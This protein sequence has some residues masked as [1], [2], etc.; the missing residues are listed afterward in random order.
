MGVRPPWALSPV[1]CRAE[2]CRKTLS[3]N[4][5]V[6]FCK[7]HRRLSPEVQRHEADYAR[8]RYVEQSRD[9]AFMASRNAARRAAMSDPKRQEEENTRQRE[10]KRHMRSDPEYRARENAER[11]E[12]YARRKSRREL[13]DVELKWVAE[14][15]VL[16]AMPYDPPEPT[17]QEPEPDE[18]SEVNRWFGVCAAV[19]CATPLRRQTKY[20]YCKEH[21][22]MARRVMPGTNCKVE[23]CRHS[24]RLMDKGSMCRPCWIS[25]DI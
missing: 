22:D 19:G 10:A 20:G 2:G 15:V 23:G 18:P 21:R 24:L 12:R 5:K 8:R 11:R 16:A 1:M 7:P 6:G 13:T 9:R 4:N 25:R 14:S 3:I 17:T